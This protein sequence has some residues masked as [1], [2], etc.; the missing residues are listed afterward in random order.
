MES[1]ALKQFGQDIWIA[2]GS[3]VSTGGF[4]YATRMAVIRLSDGTLFIW[5]PI[6]LT[7]SLQA[8]VDRLGAVRFLVAPNSLHHLFLGDWSRVYAGAELY[9]APGL[10]Q[11]RKDIAFDGDLENRPIAGWAEDIDQ[12]PV[13][14]N[15]IT[16]EVVF[17]HRKSR[18]VLFTDLIQ[19]FPAH[20]FSGWRSIVARMDLMV[21]P[22]PA[23]PRKFRNTFVDRRAARVSLAHILAWPAEK[24]L[25]A[26]GTPINEEGR[27]FIRRAF[28][29]L[30]LA[31][32]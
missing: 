5:S 24:V 14:G 21:G 26:H 10:R 9:A 3:I 28:G 6:Q 29:W 11:K 30:I 12:V 4:R 2:D 17:F 8:E 19:Q 20:W 7:G 25:M 16:T 18:T 27:T 15:L 23:V 13:P 31:N 22:E 1:V 32:N